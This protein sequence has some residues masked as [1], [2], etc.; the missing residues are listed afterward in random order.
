MKFKDRNLRQTAEMH[1]GD[2]KEFQY[3]SSSSITRFFE[4]CDLDFAH[5]GSTRWS[6]TQA[7]LSELRQLGFH[8]ISSAGHKDR[9]LEFGKDVWMRYVLPTQ[10]ILYFGI[11]AKKGKLDS[12][13]MSQGG[14]SNVADI[15]NPVL[16]MLGH[17][18]FDS[19]VPCSTQPL[20]PTRLFAALAAVR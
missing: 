16:M 20:R 8:G 12:S 9:A 5:D 18:I 11:Q 19:T 2:N 4:E 14:N 10:H 6:W 7:R 3:T 1:I 13:G 17:E 15:Y